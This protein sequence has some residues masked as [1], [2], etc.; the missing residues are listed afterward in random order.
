MFNLEDALNITL[1][2]DPAGGASDDGA[3]SRTKWLE[4]ANQD[5]IPLKKGEQT[6][7]EEETDDDDAED[8][9]DETDSDSED[10]SEEDEDEELVA[11]ADYDKV[12]QDLANARKAERHYKRLLKAHGIDPRSSARDAEAV[13][14]GK[15]SYTGPSDAEV[16]SFNSAVRAELK[17]AGF[18]AKTAKLLIG[19]FDINSFD[20]DDYIEE[21]IEEIKQEYADLLGK[22]KT[23]GQPE[24]KTRKQ[25][26]DTGV[27]RVKPKAKPNPN[28]RLI[29]AG[30]M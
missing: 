29:N 3:V 24:V 1:Y 18:D 7:E 23:A 2:A 22:G 6:V 27:K 25:R 21:R 15:D 9:V 8:E 30:L 11:K 16:R 17:L 28:S 19:Q 4:G 5:G 14:N 26:S 13:K 12:S 20:E 10:D